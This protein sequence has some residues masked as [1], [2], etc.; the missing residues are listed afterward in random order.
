MLLLNFKN[1]DG[2]G[3]GALMETGAAADTIFRFACN[4][5]KITLNIDFF[6]DRDQFFGA[7]GDA[8]SAAFALILADLDTMFFSSHD[9]GSHSLLQFTVSILQNF[10]TRTALRCFCEKFTQYF[11]ILIIYTVLYKISSKKIK[12][13]ILFPVRNW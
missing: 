8:A 13:Q 1:G 10:S 12:L 6:T 4:D 9:V 11:F 2:T 7:G 5:G 3:F